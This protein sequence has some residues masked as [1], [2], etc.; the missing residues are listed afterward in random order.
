MDYHQQNL[1]KVCGFCGLSNCGLLRSFHWTRNR[2]IFNEVYKDNTD[3]GV[4]LPT[5]FGKKCRTKLFQPLNEACRD[6][7]KA[8]VRKTLEERMHK[9]TKHTAGGCFICDQFEGQI[10]PALPL[11]D[12]SGDGDVNNKEFSLEHHKKAL[13]ISCSFCG[14][15]DRYNLRSFTFGREWIREEFD[16]IMYNN[17]HT[18]CP[19]PEKERFCRPCRSHFTAFNKITTFGFGDHP[20]R[21]MDRFHPFK[22]HTELNC[23]VCMQYHQLKGVEEENCDEENLEVEDEQEEMEVDQFFQF[24]KNRLLEVEVISKEK[25]YMDV[26]MEQEMDHIH[27]TPPFHFSLPL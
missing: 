24:H 13:S 8:A 10:Q 17:R 15:L 12:E 20:A 14:K 2:A 5:L 19:I 3:S 9:F 6:T 21:L 1:T 23:Q 11:M 4:D 16:K 7:K 27:A 25:T 22:M 18:I 26:E